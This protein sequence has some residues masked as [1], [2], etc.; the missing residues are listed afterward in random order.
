MKNRE[1][2]LAKLNPA[3]IEAVTRLKGPLLVVAGAGSGKTR[4]LTHRIA[5]LIA[6]GISPHEILAVTFT[7]KAAEEMKN[8]IRD[9]LGKKITMPTVGTFH[10]VCVQILRRE[11]QHLGR[12]NNFLIYDTTDQKLLMKR[13]FKDKHI[14]PSASSG[15][16]KNNYNPSAVLA[17]ISG[18]KSQ[19]IGP[20]KFVGGSRFGNLV[21]ELFPV[22]E[23]KLAEANALDFDDLLNK[24]VELFEKFPKILEKY[25]EKWHFIS[26]DEY[27]DT[28]LAQARIT[29]LLAEKYRNL[30]VIG[31]PDQ[32]IY[33]WRGADI[34]NIRDFKK[35]Y[36][37]AK[38]V[39]LEQNYRSTMNILEAANAIISRNG[40]REDKKL[41][42]EKTGGEKI[43]LLE[44]NDEREEAEF[45]A[46]EIERKIMES[47]YF[48]RDCVVLYR[49]NAQSRVI[50]EVF[51]RHGLPHRII[52]G[53]KFYARKEIKD[54]LSYLKIIQNPRDDISL[55]RILNVPSRKIG[56]KTVEVLQKKATEV[57]GGIWDAL[58]NCRETEIPESKKEVLERF[59]RLIED[60]QKLNRT[61]T[62]ASLIKNVLA[63]AK[64]KEYW[65]SEGEIEGEARTENVLELISVAAKYDALEPAVSL[66]TFLEEISLLS[67]AD[68]IEDKENAI[69]LMSLHAAKGLEFPIVFIAGL[70]QN[71][72]PH[73]RSLL[74]PKQL[75][76]E[77]RLFY[78]GVTRAMDNL[79][80]LRARQ[81]MFFGETQMNA[82]SEFLKDI[83]ESLLAE[84]SRR[85]LKRRGFGEK[86]LPDENQPEGS[87]PEFQ[88]GDLV[89]HPVFGEG[90]IIALVGGVVEVDFPGGVK[91]LALSIAPLRKI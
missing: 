54:V 82:P 67:D 1:E 21:A 63:R 25:Q 37:E 76:E 3:Q 48:Y 65:M 41:W 66:A 84:E 51:L 88:K 20:E 40:N 42:S 31:D 32:S 89:A 58:K 72:F 61:N 59:V 43:Y 44:M 5:Y 73:S 78:V 24:V 11:I 6:S 70:E 69:L 50:E 85:E 18:A 28:N 90:K 52:G 29:N 60:L 33:S 83:P 62:A 79:F 55:L 56:L 36:P 13:I 7:N 8:R 74:E 46:S 17:A 39:K 35:N 34:T 86:A 12:E 77:R 10:S 75:E 53:V 9:M 38:I 71:I 91:K 22:Y 68:Q 45:I 30:C 19:L 64:L 49:T 57:G 2:I 23:K 27:Q 26:V 16:E 81:R 14:D 80:L 15:Q 87:L 47:N 4:A